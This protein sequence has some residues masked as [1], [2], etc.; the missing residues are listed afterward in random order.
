LQRDRGDS[1]GAREC[2]EAGLAI[3]QE[4]EEP[5]LEAEVR[6]VLAS[7]ARRQRR[8]A[9]AAD[10]DEIA[11][12]L[13][14]QTQAGYAEVAARIGLALTYLRHD[15]TAAIE[16]ATRAAALAE[17][18]GYRQLAAQAVTALAKI[19]LAGGDQVATGKAVDE[20]SRAYWMHRATGSRHGQA[21]ALLVLAAAT[22]S[23]GRAAAAVRYRCRA[24]RILTG[25]GA[26]GP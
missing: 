22:T 1:S 19:H 9:E 8:Y 5:R 20:A 16:Q 14:A 10:H 26:V 25:M 15:A 18:A 7:V 12:R 6:N 2:A 23:A 3:A 4:I 24:E 21:E 17:R 13:A 11:L